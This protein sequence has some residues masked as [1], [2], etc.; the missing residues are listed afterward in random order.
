[1]FPMVF[2]PILLGVFVYC[3]LYM[4]THIRNG[5]I[6]IPLL[7]LPLYIGVVFLSMTIIFISYFIGIR[8]SKNNR[9]FHK[10]FIILFFVTIL[11]IMICI[12]FAR[13]DVCSDSTFIFEG[14]HNFLKSRIEKSR[15]LNIVFGITVEKYMGNFFQNYPNLAL[16]ICEG[17]IPWKLTHDSQIVE[18]VWIILDCLY[19]WGGLIGLFKILLKLFSEKF[20]RI[21]IVIL[22][23]IFICSTLTGE[24]FWFGWAYNETPCF[25][26]CV[27]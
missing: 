3:P 2:I 20:A 13:G 27:G 9:K 11:F 25:L 12:S 19:I 15:D 4:I 23:P 14:A 24:G 21:V 16:L 17:L 5:F 26:L 10:I 18:K 22:S 8:K 7:G 1:M 6:V